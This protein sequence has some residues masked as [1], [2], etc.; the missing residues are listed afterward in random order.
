MRGTLLVGY[1]VN[2][3]GVGVRRDAAKKVQ[4]YCTL[5]LRWIVFTNT[6]FTYLILVANTLKIAKTTFPIYYNVEIAPE[7][8]VFSHNRQP[9]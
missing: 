2:F 1:A 6:L 9:F 7:L 4:M 5:P 3:F 8:M